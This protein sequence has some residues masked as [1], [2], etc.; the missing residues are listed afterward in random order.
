M[1]TNYY[2]IHNN[3]GGGA[4][5]YYPNQNIKIPVTQNG[6]IYF[7]KIDATTGRVEGNAPLIPDDF[8][9]DPQIGAFGIKNAQ[10]HS[11]NDIVFVGT[12]FYG[13]WLAL[14]ANTFKILWRYN[15][16]DDVKDIPNYPNVINVLTSPVV[17]GPDVFGGAGEGPL[18]GNTPG[19]YFYCFS[20]C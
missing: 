6:N 9:S 20:V 17:A 2:D 3:L 14:D 8:L 1:T 18:G 13:H 15:I 19:K 7:T 4:G 16:Y 12:S 10:V 11:V 5:R